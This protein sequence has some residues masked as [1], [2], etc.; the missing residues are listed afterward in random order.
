MVMKIQQICR[1][2]KYEQKQGDNGTPVAMD[3]L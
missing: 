3:L 1:K 2:E